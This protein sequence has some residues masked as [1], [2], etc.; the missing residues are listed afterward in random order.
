MNNLI[1]GPGTPIALAFPIVT[2]ISNAFCDS[3]SLSVRKPIT[4]QRMHWQFYFKKPNFSLPLLS[5]F[6]LR[7]SGHCIILIYKGVE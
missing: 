5:D 3:E 1:P 2:T 6:S 7:P 4:C